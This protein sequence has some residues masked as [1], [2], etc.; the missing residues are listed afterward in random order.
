[1]TASLRPFSLAL[2]TPLATA[3]GT[4]ERREGFILEYHAEGFTG[5]G[6][7]A[8]L[9]GWTESFRETEVAL[10]QAT[11]ALERADEAAARTAVAGRPAAAHAL[12][13]A[14][15]DRRA[16]RA[17]R[18]LYRYLGTGE[19]VRS[20]PV[21]A[22]LGDADL[23]TV[24]RQ[25]TAATGQGFETLKL[26]VGAR[27]PDADVE[28]VRA[29]REAIG[30][31]PAIRLDANGAWDLATAEGLWPRFEDLGVELVEQPLPAT[32]LGDHQSLRGT[33]GPRV[34]LD[35]GVM[36]HGLGRVLR[37]GVAD[38]VVIKPMVLGGVEQAA[39]SVG[40]ASD[41][42]VDPIVT[43]TIDA[44][45]ARTTAVHVAA[46]ID[47]PIACGLATAD[48]LADDVAPDPAPVR[49]GRI[50]VPQ[51]P[52]HGVTLAETGENE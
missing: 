34:A 33:S 25:A 50:A 14:T 35:E 44:V 41:A 17:D 30:D 31:R 8:P 29:V 52:G 11:A 48:R 22:T 36:E 49:D 15:L 28:R 6:E 42:G 12:D 19:S 1:M 26:K 47:C 32:E 40:Q 43:T 21:N 20:V 38:A 3:T 16:K 23:G 10:R 9:P 27:E 4:L 51:D 37:A 24:S 13:G 7:A 18:P 5:V 2:S 39:A 46:T 45:I